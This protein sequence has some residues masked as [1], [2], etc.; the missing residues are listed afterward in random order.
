MHNQP[1][2]DPPL[3]VMRNTQGEVEIGGFPQFTVPEYVYRKALISSAKDKIPG[4]RLITRL[5]THVYTQH[6]LASQNAT[7]KTKHKAAYPKL[8]TTGLQA[9]FTQ[10]RIQF[11]TFDDNMS[12][13]ACET[14]KAINNICKKRR[15]ACVQNQ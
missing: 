8:H 11:P 13:A 1:I 5:I 3:A 7:G 4:R 9:L 12:D 10:A 14:N 6:E 2:D 15:A